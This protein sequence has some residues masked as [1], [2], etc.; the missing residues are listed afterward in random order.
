MTDKNTATT[1]RVE[2]IET[3]AGVSRMALSVARA[4]DRLPAG[5]TYHV[6]IVKPEMQSLG[7]RVEIVRDERIQTLNLRYNP[8]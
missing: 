2:L 5:Y 6:E 8:E 3:D 4:V 7:W 1:E